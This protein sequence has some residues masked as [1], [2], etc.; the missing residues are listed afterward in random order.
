[1]LRDWLVQ[2]SLMPKGVDHF[3]HGPQSPERM[4]V[5][6][7]LMPK[8]VDHSLY[9]IRGIQDCWVQKSLMPKGVDHIK[10]RDKEVLDAVKCKNL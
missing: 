2:K 9:L 1:M 5:Q 10:T 8:G 3:I 4:L 6:K 7:S